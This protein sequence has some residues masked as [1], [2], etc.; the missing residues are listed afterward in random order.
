MMVLSG[1]SLRLRLL[2][3][4]TVD[5]KATEYKKRALLAERRVAILE[6]MVEEKT[7][8]IYQHY[9]KLK[10]SADRLASLH[11]ILPQA[12][13]VADA[14]GKLTQ[15]NPAAEVLIGA[16]SHMLIGQP[17]E[18]YIELPLSPE[19]TDKQLESSERRIRT[20]SGES[21]PVLTSIAELNFSPD[22]D[23]DSEYV[24]ICT[25]L[26][27][28]NRLELELRHAQKME[29]IGQL[30]SGIA[31]EINT[32]MQFIGDNVFFLGKAFS[33]V[34]GYIDMV[35]LASNQEV[36]GEKDIR[37]NI[38]AEFQ[39]RDLEFFTEQV[40]KCI[41]RTQE[42]VRRIS[43]IVSA[44]RDFSHPG[45]EQ[46]EVNLNEVIKG[47]LTLARG[48]YKHLADI[49]LDLE[50]SSKVKASAS[51]IGQVFVN[52][53]VN[54]SQAFEEKKRLEGRA[55]G[56]GTIE[57]ESRNIG[58]KVRVSVK[59]NGQGIPESIKHRV[60]DPFFT[61]KEVGK[62]T[63]QGLAITHNIVERHGGKI[64]FNSEE[65]KGTT[66]FVELGLID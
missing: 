30:V 23:D 13:L 19:S 52:M 32:P 62:G 25:D 45:V 14:G 6:E 26:R 7:R 41:D 20:S 27:E 4:K 51:E 35:N 64:W 47:A 58:R 11:K 12:I 65:G 60:F 10:Q 43:K 21:V 22:S 31:H 50:A 56:M 28:R 29:S 37:A 5:M 57:I 8:E 9:R 24:I 17:L 66:F 39:K 49:N 33:E 59:D 3:P 2:L 61:T 1:V 54:A 44:M 15:V 16:N 48:Q 53:I 42:G 38:K 46:E 34:L 55:V 36:D 18:D 63:G 40:P